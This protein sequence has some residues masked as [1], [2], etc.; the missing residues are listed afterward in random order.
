[1]F[2]DSKAADNVSAPSF[3][4]KLAAVLGAPRMVGTVA[5]HLALRKTTLEHRF[6]ALGYL[7]SADT[8]E[9][10]FLKPFENRYG[11]IGCA[12]IANFQHS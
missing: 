4:L 5:A 10:K 9:F 11:C 12:G 6:A 8:Q 7:R 2:A 3:G 1:M